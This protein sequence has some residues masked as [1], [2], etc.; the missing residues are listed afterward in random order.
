[1]LQPGTLV[2]YRRPH[3]RDAGLVYE[4]S[5]VRHDGSEVWVLLVEEQEDDVPVRPNVMGGFGCWERASE[6]VV[7]PPQVIS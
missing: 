7:V 1:M 5:K 2:Q 6:F 3:P 4:V